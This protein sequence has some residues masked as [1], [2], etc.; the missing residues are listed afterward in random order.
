MSLCITSNRTPPLG[1]ITSSLL[2]RQATDLKPGSQIGLGQ[3]QIAMQQRHAQ[4]LCKREAK[5]KL[6]LTKK[7]QQVNDHSARA[8]GAGDNETSYFRL[9]HNRTTG[10]RIKTNRIVLI[11]KIKTNHVASSIVIRETLGG[12]RLRPWAMCVMYS[13][14]FFLTQPH[15]L[16]SYKFT[17]VRPC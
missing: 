12:D 16:I 13:E 5:L 9:L 10:R 15:V 4:D 17:V 11:K 2:R 6:A 1:A 7:R 8:A 14:F 3:A